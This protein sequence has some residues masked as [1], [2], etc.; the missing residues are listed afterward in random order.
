M[1]RARLG[2]FTHAGFTT[3]FRARLRYKYSAG[4][5][6]SSDFFPFPRTRDGRKSKTAPLRRLEIVCVRTDTFGMPGPGR[7]VNRFHLFWKAFIF[8]N[9][10][11]VAHLGIRNL[12]GQTCFHDPSPFSRILLSIPSSSLT[13][14]SRR[15]RRRARRDFR[16]PLVSSCNARDLFHNYYYALSFFLYFL[17]GTY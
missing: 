17:S 14:H 3:G 5:L 9:V 11:S 10:F 8:F 15:W 16:R 6:W 1:Y 7:F 12:T 2:N 13:R 4:T